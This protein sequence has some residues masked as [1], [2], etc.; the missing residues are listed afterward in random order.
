[1]NL[2]IWK[3]SEEVKPAKATQKVSK[4]QEKN[5]ES[6]VTD[7]KRGKLTTGPTLPD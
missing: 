1:M 2:S 3:A 4:P 5:Q 6:R 7:G